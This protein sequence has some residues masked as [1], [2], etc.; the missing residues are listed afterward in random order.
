MLVGVGAGRLADRH[1]PV[2]GAAPD[3]RVRLGDVSGFDAAIAGQNLAVE[4][5]QLGHTGHLLVRLQ[6]LYLGAAPNGIDP[7]TI[8]E[9][10]HRKDTH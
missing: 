4:R 5:C 6:S 3:D 2:A 9:A 1:D 7:A 10:A 8:I